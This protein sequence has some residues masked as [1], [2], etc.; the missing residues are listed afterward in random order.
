M[1]DHLTRK[2]R[3][4]NMSLIRSKDTKPELIVR[5]LLHRMGYRFRLHQKG[6]PGKPDI[7]LKKHNTVVF[8]H[9][10]F[11]HQHPGC[12]RATI[13]KTNTDYWIP[14]LKKNVTRF[15]DVHEQLSHQGWKVLVVWECE[16]KNIDTLTDKIKIFLMD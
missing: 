11:W 7:V 5:S 13:P 15:S 12:K 8:C 4:W 14:K 1:V 9:G 6:L 16:T 3:S 2:L 10:C